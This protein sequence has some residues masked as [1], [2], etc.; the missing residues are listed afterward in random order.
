M[1]RWTGRMFCALVLA[2]GAATAMGGRRASARLEVVWVHD[3]EGAGADVCLW[4]D[5]SVAP[6]NWLHEGPEVVVEDGVP[7]PRL[8]ELGDRDRHSNYRPTPTVIHGESGDWQLY[9]R[10]VESW[11]H[12]W[13]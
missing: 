5:G 12:E 4:P 13:D 8:V 6:G 1:Q 7:R 3:L 11:K 10:V 2:A 9:A